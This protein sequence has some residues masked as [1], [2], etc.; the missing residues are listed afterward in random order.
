M[1]CSMG[2]SRETSE[3]LV[4]RAREGDREAFD[5]LILR[6][7]DR[8]DAWVRSSLG[9]ELKV[10]VSS[11]D[12]LQET[13]LWAFK[14]IGN[15]RWRG[16]ASFGHWLV[17]I[18]KHVLFKEAR[19]G[20]HACLELERDTAGGGVT[21]SR[22]VRR[23]ERFDRLEKALADL[24]P[25]H[26]H[27]VELA[28]IEGLPVKEIARRMDRSPNATSQLLARALKK[29]RANFGDTES[30]GLPERSLRQEGADDDR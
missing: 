27:V 2:P 5:A 20:K 6:F 12:V 29:L 11:E 18:A 28:R 13:F 1:E 3:D 17:S 15:L 19:K 30:L 25:E 21:P 24:S 9:P 23:D 16:E 26:R 7:R 8:L 10:R 22:L 14:G 4:Q